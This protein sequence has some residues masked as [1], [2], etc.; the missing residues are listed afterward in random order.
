MARAASPSHG[1]LL[2]LPLS[3]WPTETRLLLGL[4]VTWCLFGL[5][6]LLSASWWPSLQDTGSGF[7]TI[8][9]QL[10][11]LAI[12]WGLLLVVIPPPSGGCCTWRG[13][14]CCWAA[15]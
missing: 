1:G 9:R 2:P 12:S 11:W 14:R 13:P 8:Q 10:I 15:C 6:V 7:Y 4:V 5:V 3:V